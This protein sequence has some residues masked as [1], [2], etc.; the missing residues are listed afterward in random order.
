MSI[1][2][3][4]YPQKRIC[5]EFYGV[6]D[7]LKTHGAK[8]YNKN[9]HW[10]RW[11]WLLGHSNLDEA[12][13]PPIGLYYDG[14]KIIGI[15]T[16]DMREPA[17]I[18]LNPQYADLKREMVEY[19][20]SELSNDSVSRLFADQDDDELI[21]I[22]REKGY[23]QTNAA[24]HT[25]QLDCAEKLE[26]RLGDGFSFTDYS[27]DKSIDK[28]VSV[29]HKGFGNAGEPAKGL[30][31]T[32]FLEKPHEIPQLDLFVVAQSGEYA[33]HC[34]TWYS[35]DTEICYIEPVVTIPE[36]RKQGLGK[37]VVYECVNRCIDM[38]A[39][40]AIVI[41]NQQFYHGIGFKEYSISS[42]WEKQL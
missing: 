14:N 19:A 39:K 8:G 20:C 33:A 3:K 9:W 25:L 15:V 10:A 7:F 28:Y 11:E 21:S 16:H 26:Y 17:Y 30:E 18:L 42:L 13:L 29:I 2:L 12:T 24:E 31:E 37:A 35:P 34:G 23:S 38:G 1:Y 27:I 32:D 36:Y 41:S 40:K 6:I 4:H 22:L 5:D